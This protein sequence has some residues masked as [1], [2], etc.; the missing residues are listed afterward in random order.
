MLVRI[1]FDLKQIAYTDKNEKSIL[2]EM[3]DGV[4]KQSQ[5]FHVRDWEVHSIYDSL[6]GFYFGCSN[7]FGTC[8]LLEHSYNLS[9][10]IQIERLMEENTI[11]IHDLNVTG[12]K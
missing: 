1:H 4:W 10:N 6:D 8:L 12:M 5:L 7:S 3:E 2:E 9:I 11:H